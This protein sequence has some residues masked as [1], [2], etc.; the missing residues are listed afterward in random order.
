MFKACRPV[1]T[2]PHLLM[3]VTG[4][5]SVPEEAVEP[6]LCEFGLQSIGSSDYLG[7]DFAILQCVP[8][9]LCN[10]LQNKQERLGE[11]YKKSFHDKHDVS[12]D[13]E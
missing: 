6:F 4:Q 11:E 3:R 12:R 13:Q 5:L 7:E 10:H 2:V 1:Q 8:C 9:K